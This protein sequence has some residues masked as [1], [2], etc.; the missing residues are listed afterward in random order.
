MQDSPPVWYKAAITDFQS[1]RGYSRDDVKNASKKTKFFSQYESKMKYAIYWMSIEWRI[2]NYT[3]CH[4]LNADAI[5]WMKNI[6]PS[7]VVADWK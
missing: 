5:Y 1:Y 2:L 3:Y 7:I 4:L 6:I